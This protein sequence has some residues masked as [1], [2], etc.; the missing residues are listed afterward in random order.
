MS[1]LKTLETLKVL[2]LVLGLLHKFVFKLLRTCYL[3]CKFWFVIIYLLVLLLP[4]L[5]KIV[6]L[7]VNMF[8]TLLPYLPKVSFSKVL[9]KAP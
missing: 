4:Q 9:D 7:V 8:Q 5:A 3:S 1:L 6:C 2:K